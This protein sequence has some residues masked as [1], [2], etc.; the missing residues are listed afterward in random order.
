MR[1]GP[2]VTSI[3]EPRTRSPARGR[4]F[5]REGLLSSGG[6]IVLDGIVYSEDHPAAVIN[7]R[8]VSTGSFVDGAEVLRI[9]PDRVELKDGSAT[10]VVSL[11]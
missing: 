4:S 3:E 7:G 9:R 2:S 8:V 6:R 1:A 5:V 10:I 11:R